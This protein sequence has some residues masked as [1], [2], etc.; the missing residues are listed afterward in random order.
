MPTAAL[1]VSPTARTSHRTQVGQGFL[2]RFDTS[3][4]A[5]PPTRDSHLWIDSKV[6]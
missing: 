3:F 2:A 4:T 1:A 6:R 5:G